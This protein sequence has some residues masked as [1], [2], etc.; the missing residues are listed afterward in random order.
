M[1]V[2]FNIMHFFQCQNRLSFLNI[3][4]SFRNNQKDM[5]RIGSLVAGPEIPSVLWMCTQVA[6]N[7]R[8]GLNAEIDCCLHPDSD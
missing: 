5:E 4:M 7:A 2:V 3:A 1:C 6:L 8:T